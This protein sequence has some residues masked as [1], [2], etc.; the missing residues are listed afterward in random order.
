MWLEAELVPPAIG[1]TMCLRS[2]WGTDRGHL[3]LVCVSQPVLLQV[4][5][6]PQT[7]QTDGRNLGAYDL[8]S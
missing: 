5:A 4:S 1:W 6:G 7:H 8:G 2:C 3:Q